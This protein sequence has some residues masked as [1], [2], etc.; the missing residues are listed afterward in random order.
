MKKTTTKRLVWFCVGNGIAWVWCSYILAFLGR[1]A[2]AESLSTAAVTEI[3]GVVL[4]YG[5]KSLLEKRKD[6]GSVGEQ[7]WEETV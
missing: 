1:Y 3:L 4:V 6:F 5:L 2:I 7:N